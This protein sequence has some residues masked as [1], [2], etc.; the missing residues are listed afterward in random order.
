MEFCVF[1]LI[2]VVGAFLWCY[3]R[4]ISS[5]AAAIHEYAKRVDAARLELAQ[6]VNA[7]IVRLDVRADALKGRLGDLEEAV[8]RSPV[9]IN[10]DSLWKCVAHLYDSDIHASQRDARLR[11]S[12]VRAGLLEAET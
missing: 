8:G 1:L 2:A 12:L 9:D 11:S 10:Y 7:E 3:C 5:N 4:R 6:S